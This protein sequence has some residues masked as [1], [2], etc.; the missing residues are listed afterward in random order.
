MAGTFFETD[1][2][3]L[4]SS[5]FGE[6]DIV[7]T[8][9]CVQEGRLTAIAKGA[10]KSKKRFVNKLE[11]FSFLHIRY[12]K[13]AHNSLALL[14]EAELH[15]GF[16][17]IRND[18]KLFGFASV[19]REYLLLGI[20]E[21]ETDKTLF[22]LTTWVLHNLDKQGQTESL[23]VLFLVRYFGHIGYQ[24]T[25]THCTTCLKTV[26][27][28]K[29]YYFLVA[30]GGLI[31]SDCTSNQHRLTLV[32]H[33]TIKILHSAQEQPLERLHILKLSGKMGKQSLALLRKY[34][35]YLFQK[36]VISW[37]VLNQ[38]TR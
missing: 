34:G 4:D 13:K 33:G 17:E 21:G 15:T 14:L 20:K 10:R 2:I 16:L 12:K 35:T 23:L 36:E 1:A 6:S 11:I 30:E 29:S 28:Q 31:C 9:F 24:P 7:I 5:D 38:L 22:Q 19:I 27:Q 32:P 26:S 3:V 25:L 37:S 8:F 18:P